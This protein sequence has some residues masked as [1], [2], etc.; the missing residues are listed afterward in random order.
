MC[1][2]NIEEELDYLGMCLRDCHRCCRI[3]FEEKLDE[4]R[5]NLK[6]EP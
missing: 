1:P 5:D 2:D 4:L 3:L 6:V